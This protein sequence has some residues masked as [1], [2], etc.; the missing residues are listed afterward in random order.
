MDRELLRKRAGGDGHTGADSVSSTLQPTSSTK[1]NLTRPR[2][3]LCTEMRRR[4]QSREVRRPHTAQTRVLREASNI[5][6]QTRPGPPHHRAAKLKVYSDLW[7][8]IIVQDE[9]YGKLLAKNA[10]SGYVEP[11]A[12]RIRNDDKFTIDGGKSCIEEIS[13]KDSEAVRPAHCVADDLPDPTIVSTPPLFPDRVRLSADLPKRPECVP[14]LH[15]NAR[16]PSS[17]MPNAATCST[18]STVMEPASIAHAHERLCHLDF[19]TKQ[20]GLYV[21]VTLKWKVFEAGKFTKVIPKQFNNEN[22]LNL[23]P[24][25]A[26]FAA[27]KPF[28]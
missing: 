14:R 4:P 8:A 26:V 6:G 24:V 19:E 25:T 22:K 28:L 18:G 27:A 15:L 1:P 17:N 2:S 10:S 23:K 3:A 12:S 20:N 5:P 11:V 9:A 7:E 21:P 16:R 13:L